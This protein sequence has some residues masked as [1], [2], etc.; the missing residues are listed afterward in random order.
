MKEEKLETERQQGR[1]EPKIEQVFLALARKLLCS[2]NHSHLDQTSV[3]ELKARDIHVWMLGEEGV[4]D[5]QQPRQ[6]LQTEDE[7][8]KNLRTTRKKT[9][10]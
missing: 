1:L 8:E 4:E 3:E 5:Y 7:E 2:P 10:V 9:M 6:T